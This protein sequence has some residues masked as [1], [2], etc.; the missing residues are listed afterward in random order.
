MG[1]REQITALLNQVEQGIKELEIAYELY[2]TGIEKRAPEKL[3]V[4][5]TKKI[6]NLLALHITQNDLKFKL[7]SLSSRYQ[8]Y[9]GRWDRILRMIDEGRYK[10]HHSLL[11]NRSESAISRSGKSMNNE[12]SQADRLYEQLLNAHDDC[13]LKAPS[14]EQVNNFLQKQEEAIKK[15]FGDKKVDFKVTTEAGKPKIKVF[16]KA[17]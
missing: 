11:K 14:K 2:F 4:N 12:R 10:R 9:S 8:S 7:N 6:R 3:R 5:L 17:S 1:S 16:A 15:K 13:S